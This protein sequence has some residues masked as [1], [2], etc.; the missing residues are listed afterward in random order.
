MTK[1]THEQKLQAIREACIAASN[2]PLECKK[3]DCVCDLHSELGLA[4]VL[5]A[6]DYEYKF[7]KLMA[8]VH[9]DMDGQ[10]LMQ[11]MSGNPPEGTGIYWNRKKDLDNQSEETVALIY[12]LVK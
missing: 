10:F 9:L 7:G 5:M 1:M 4:D 3:G 6:I 8:M 12:D 2:L 11:K